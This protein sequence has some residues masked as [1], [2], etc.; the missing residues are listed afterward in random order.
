VTARTVPPQWNC[1]WGDSWAALASAAAARAA[2][3]ALGLVETSLGPRSSHALPSRKTASCVGGTGG[4][5]D[6][7]LRT[8]TSKA[9]GA[10][11]RSPRS[12]SR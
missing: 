5:T 9:T 3:T 12:I 10:R 4:P 7:S 11:P 8:R 2:A 1:S 6:G